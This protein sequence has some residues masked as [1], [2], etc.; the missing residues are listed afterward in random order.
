MTVLPLSQILK[1]MLR[2]CLEKYSNF[3]EVRFNHRVVNIG[4]DE[5]KAWANVEISTAG[6]EMK[7]VTLA[8][9]YLIGCDGSQSVVRK[10]LFQ[11]DWPGDTF[12]S[13]LLVQNVFYD[14]F[15]KYGWDGGNYMIDSEYWGLV[16]KRGKAKGNDGTLWRVTYGDSAKN[17]S[18]DE[19]LQ[20]REIAFKKLLPGHPDPGQYKITQTDVFRMHNR[21]VKTMR[22]GRI[23]LAADA[24]HV[25]NP[26]GGY[27]CMAAVLDVGGLADCLAGYYEGRANEDILDLYAKIRREKFINFID[28]RSRKNLDRISKTDPNT[29]LQ[30][31]PFLGILRRLEGDAKGTKDFLLKVSSIEYDFTRHYKA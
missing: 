18:D 29:V 8:A 10:C 24:A 19:Y 2:H 26:F 30:T 28:R 23:L 25:N 21:C 22:V 17:L 31:D 9:D 16:A 6:E 11:R 20:R 27:G 1:I 12:D 14:G 5:T 7:T 15:E 13:R 3:V 4:Q